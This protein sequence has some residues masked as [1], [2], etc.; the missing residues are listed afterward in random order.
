MKQYRR[1]IILVA[2]ALAVAS[3]AYILR[4]AT[5]PMSAII[6]GERAALA[7]ALS[8]KGS[9]LEPKE[10]RRSENKLKLLGY[11][12]AMAYNAEGKPD[13]AITVLEQLI[14]EEQA[15][16]PRTSL[17][18][19]EEARYQGILAVSYELRG[20]HEAAEKARSAQGELTSLSVQTKK[21]ERAEEGKVIHR[22]GD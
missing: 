17:S 15:K 12:L 7:D 6:A 3:V 14:Q 16:E 22:K 9:S 2:A 19:H 20:D 8:R 11:Q 18:Y 13:R 4:G 10:L 5:R 21:K 1:I